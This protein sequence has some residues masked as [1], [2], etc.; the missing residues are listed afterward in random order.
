M[1]YLFWK[2]DS[3]EGCPHLDELYCGNA[4]NEHRNTPVSGVNYI[5]EAVIEIPDWCP[6]PNVP[7]GFDM[8]VSFGYATTKPEEHSD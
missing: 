6:L 7:E 3:C 1:K 8:V 2:G 4:P 5:G